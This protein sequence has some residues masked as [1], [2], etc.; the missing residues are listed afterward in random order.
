MPA[1]AVVK[2]FD[3]GEN[4][5]AMAADRTV[6]V[7]S[8]ERMTSYTIPSGETF[9]APPGK[10]FL[11]INVTCRNVG[12]T[13][14]LTG[15]AYFLLADS[16]GHSYK[17]QTY[18]GYHFSKPYP[19]AGLS[20][21]VTVSGQILWIVPMSASGLAVSYLLDSGSNPPVMAR[22]KLPW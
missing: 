8:T 18:S 13:S 11:F 17:D 20:P 5:W 22:W 19:N 21:S 1:N 12:N 10:L 7:S 16:A 3:I 6:M 15:P 9:T 2:Y 14:L 4:I